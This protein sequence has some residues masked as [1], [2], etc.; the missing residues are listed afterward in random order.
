MGPGGISSSVRSGI[1]PAKAED[2]APDGAW[3]F[4]K[5]KLQIC[6]ASGAPLRAMNLK[7]E[8]IVLE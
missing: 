7:A 6:R 1:F 5:R 3:I 4:G 2:A 8:A